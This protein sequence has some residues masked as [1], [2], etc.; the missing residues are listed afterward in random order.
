MAATRRQGDEGLCSREVLYRFILSNIGDHG[1]MDCM[2]T[3]AGTAAARPRPLFLVL[4]QLDSIVHGDT[5][6]G[7]HETVH[8]KPRI[9]LEGG[10]GATRLREKHCIVGPKLHVSAA[11]FG[12]PR[13][14]R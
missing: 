7:L 2:G 14:V 3:L 11:S 8:I 5:V 12:D 13:Q 9:L 10:G 6:K 1:L 4:H